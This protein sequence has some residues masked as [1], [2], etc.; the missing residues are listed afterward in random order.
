MS[1]RIRFVKW[2][3]AAYFLFK[4]WILD[5][6][7]ANQGSAQSLPCSSMVAKWAN[8]WRSVTT[9]KLWLQ[10]WFVGWWRSHIPDGWS[11]QE[12]FFRQKINDSDVTFLNLLSWFQMIFILSYQAILKCKVQP[13]TQVKHCSITLR[14]Y[15][16]K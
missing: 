3:L 13:V 14:T 16:P 11:N 5:E 8:R 12:F 9:S 10:Y 15:P 2:I 6:N 7:N 1:I 4:N